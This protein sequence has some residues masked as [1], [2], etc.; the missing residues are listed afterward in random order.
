LLCEVFLFI[1][2]KWNL[3]A[4]KSYDMGPPH[5]RKAVDFYRS[6]K[7]HRLGRV[8]IPGPWVQWQGR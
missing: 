7:L 4:V 6:Y 5:R 1:L 3:H 8:S 2:P